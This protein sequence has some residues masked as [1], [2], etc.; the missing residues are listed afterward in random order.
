MSL[1]ICR[2]ARFSRQ[3]GCLHING[4]SQTNNEL[5]NKNFNQI[6]TVLLY[7]ASV[8][9]QWFLLSTL[10]FLYIYVGLC[11]IDQIYRIDVERRT[12]K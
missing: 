2:G 8:S 3:F 7:V 6:S 9:R 12:P 11:F 5:L 10:Q 4:K 1:Y